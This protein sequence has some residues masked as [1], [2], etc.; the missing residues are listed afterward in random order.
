MKTKHHSIQ[1]RPISIGGG[2]FA[3]L[4]PVTVFGR[5]LEQLKISF[6]STRLFSCYALP[7]DLG[8]S[9]PAEQ[10]RW[11]LPLM[12]ANETIYRLGRHRAPRSA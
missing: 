11:A 12:E 7:C 6:F 8:L 5:V 9:I 4:A 2:S 3:F 10:D 1:S